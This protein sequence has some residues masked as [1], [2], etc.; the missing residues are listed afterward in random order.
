MS[1]TLHKPGDVGGTERGKAQPLVSKSLGEE[2]IN[3]G[4]VVLQRRRGQP[5][6]LYQVTPE[7]IGHVLPRALYRRFSVLFHRSRLAEPGQES[8]QYASVAAADAIVALAML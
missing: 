3:E 8:T 5:T 7:L 1:V 6:F 4:Y 2:L